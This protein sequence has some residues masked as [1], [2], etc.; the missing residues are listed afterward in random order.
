MTVLIG[1]RPEGKPPEEHMVECMCELLTA[2]GY[3]LESKEPGSRILQ[4]AIARLIEIK[5]N[6]SKRVQFRIDDLLDLRSSGWQ[7][8][9]YRAKAQTLDVIRREALKDWNCGGTVAS[10]TTAKAGLQPAYMATEPEKSLEIAVERSP[11]TYAPESISD[12]SSA[13][14]SF[15][16]SFDPFSIANLVTRFSET[17]DADALCHDWLA[18]TPNHHEAAKGVRQILWAGLSG[19]GS[20]AAS[21]VVELLSHRYVTWDH[22]AGALSMLICPEEGDECEEESI[23]SLRPTMADEENVYCSVLASI[24]NAGLFNPIAFRSLPRDPEHACQLLTGVLLYVKE[25]SSVVV[26]HSVVNEIWEVLCAVKG[27]PMDL[28]EHQLFSSLVCD[29]FIDEDIVLP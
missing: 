16:S 28:S 1:E 15:G 12:F 2:I 8:K 13:D 14:F 18:L 10:F 17:K 24:F 21:V 20:A 27:V 7:Q 19:E 25:E 9:V 4:L 11:S 3:T 29:G 22:L 23:C 26:Q 6:F 5:C